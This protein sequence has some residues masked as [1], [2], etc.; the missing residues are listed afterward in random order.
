MTVD[1]VKESYN[2]FT[3]YPLLSYNCIT[4]L[5]ENEDTLWKLLAY[6][7]ADAW[8]GTDL[9]KTEK[10]N[11][12]YRG[13]PE[14]TQYRVFMDVGQDISW[15]E[16]ACILRISPLEITP[17]N[18]IYGN[19]VMGFEVYSHYRI[20]H[21]SNYQT[22]IDMCIQRLIEAFNGQDIGGLGRLYFDARAYSRSKVATIGQIPFKGKGLI[23]CNW[24]AS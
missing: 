17:T 1:I 6:N 20:N 10:R 4:Y 5:I 7:D 19:V 12:V 8:N 24:M 18:H 15:T 14:E 13:Q 2:K 9:T 23:M 22:R 16:Q 3:D 21:L 11:L